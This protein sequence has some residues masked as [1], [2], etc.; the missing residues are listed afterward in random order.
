MRQMRVL[1][2]SA[3]A[4]RIGLL[5]AVR[6]TGRS[7]PSRFASRANRPPTC[8]PERLN[9]SWRHRTAGRHKSAETPARS[10][11]NN[12]RYGATDQMGETWK[13]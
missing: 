3:N 1:C 8:H 5:Q 12:A 10:A 11:S 7:S 9:H 2:S 6:P 13:L 4:M